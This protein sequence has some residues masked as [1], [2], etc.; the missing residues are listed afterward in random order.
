MIKIIDLQL[1]IGDLR[2]QE[3]RAMKLFNILLMIMIMNLIL[4]HHYT[5]TLCCQLTVIS[6]RDNQSDYH[7]NKWVCHLTIIVNIKQITEVCG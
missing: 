5:G 6:N 7:N 1:N 2:S 3:C 4:R